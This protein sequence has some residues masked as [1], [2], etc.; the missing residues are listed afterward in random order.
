MS[1]QT[2]SSSTSSAKVN[3]ALKVLAQLR[4]KRE[5]E[6]AGLPTDAIHDESDVENDS[7]SPIFDRFYANGGS[8]TLMEMSNFNLT[9]SSVC[10]IAAAPFSRNPSCLEGVKKLMLH[11]KTYFSLSSVFLKQPRIGI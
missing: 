10:G 6:M 5:E 11:Q 1:K 8:Q 4:E 3:H 7:L 2:A 9:K